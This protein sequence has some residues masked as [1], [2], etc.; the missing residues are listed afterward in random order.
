MFR[1]LPNFLTL[2]N[3]FV[4]SVA[5][6]S[7]LLGYSETGL[8]GIAC[9]LLLDYLDGFTARLFN[10]KHPMGKDLDSLADVVSFGFV[11]GAIYFHLFKKFPE[12]IIDGLEEIYPFVGFFFTVFAALRLAKFN[13]DTRQSDQ[14]LGLP[15]PA[16]TIFTAG[17]LFLSLDSCHSCNTIL[18]NPW[19]LWISLV[20]LCGLMVS[21]LPMF[22]LKFNQYGWKGNE[23]KWIYIILCVALLILMKEAA[24][25][26]VI[27]LYI[28]LSLL[29]QKKNVVSS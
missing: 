20:I 24:F 28:F 11:P 18:L 14:F 10:I 16:A 7:I 15:T 22:N 3:L 1:N 5:G 17:L 29:F 19:T 13:I 26:L 2:L 23:A 4:G 25:S 8:V 12:F 27:V 21:N 6:T 9:C